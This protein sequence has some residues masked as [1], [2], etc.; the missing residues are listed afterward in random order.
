MMLRTKLSKTLIAGLIA[1]GC[2]GTKM[3][4]NLYSTVRNG[5]DLIE[6]QSANPELD[7]KPFGVLDLYEVRRNNLTPSLGAPSLDPTSKV[8]LVLDRLAKV[9][10]TRAANYQGYLDTFFAEA[11]IAAHLHLPEIPDEAA[12]H[13]P[14]DDCR[15]T[16]LAMQQ[17]PALPQDK[18]YVIRKEI[19]DQLDNDN[20]AALMLHEIIFREAR[21]LDQVDSPVVR[22]YNSQLITDQF[23]GMNYQQYQSFMDQWIK[24]PALYLFKNK[25]AF[26]LKSI[27]FY[28]SG[29]FRTGTTVIAPSGVTIYDVKVGL[30]VVWIY[31]G[32]YMTF[33]DNGNFEAAGGK[34]VQFIHEESNRP[35]GFYFYQG[36]AI[37]PTSHQ[38]LVRISEIHV[39]SG[40]LTDLTL[41]YPELFPACSVKNHASLTDFTVK[42]KV[43]FHTNG[44]VSQVTLSEPGTFEKPDGSSVA[45][46]AGDTLS[47]DEDGNLR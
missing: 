5:G 43:S 22:F 35:D 26:S 15:I 42:G 30:N 2:G 7:G 3:N 36:C 6:C 32:G 16:Q 46:N 39:S 37:D 41:A 24:F 33:A 10:P 20:Q 29:N 40:I 9:D 18:R 11:E 19:W 8:K 44:V 4:N 27:E 12:V 25:Y 28:P 47:F 34:T 14:G 23:H 13:M 17:T 1:T 21:E 45:Y 38:D 31:S